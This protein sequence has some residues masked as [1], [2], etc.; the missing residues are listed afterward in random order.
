MTVYV[1]SSHVEPLSNVVEPTLR[2]RTGISH[3][4]ATEG[5]V[6]ASACLFSEAK[7]G[8]GGTGLYSYP[9][10]PFNFHLNLLRPPGQI[11]ED[12]RNEVG[13]DFTFRLTPRELEHLEEC[14][15]HNRKHDLILN[16][17]TQVTYLHPMSTAYDLT[18]F[19]THIGMGPNPDKRSGFV[20]FDPRK[21][22]NSGGVS[23]IALSGG[24]ALFEVVTEVVKTTV[25]VPS[26]D[27]INDFVPAFG[28]GTFIVFEVPDSTGLAVPQELKERFVRATL[29][30]A[31][32]KNDMAQ[33]EWPECIRHS[34]DVWD[35]TRREDV[36]KPYLIG[37]GLSDAAAMNLL[38]SMKT[39]FDFSS[40][41]VKA[42]EVGSGEVNPVLPASKEDAYFV[43]ALATSMVNLL[44]RKA[45]KGKS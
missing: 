44:S 9:G 31:S 2:I 20:L 1:S 17:E 41:F 34:R 11:K 45:A 14:R 35:L 33:G 29:A 6:C 28:L 24:D 18:V 21:E 19:D 23:V 37:G 13:V 15:N 43:Y 12:S 4:V 42:A 8:I 36:L 3:S 22:G 5:F 10:T 39:M 25:T 32:M 26:S 38:A 27:W 40:K 7:R 16:V 30:V